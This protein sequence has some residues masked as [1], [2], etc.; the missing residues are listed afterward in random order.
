L[1][2]SSS[3]AGGTVLPDGDAGRLSSGTSVAAAAT[4]V[5]SPEPEPAAL[6]ESSLAVESG[7]LGVQRGM[8]GRD[9]ESTLEAGTGGGAAPE[10][11]DETE[12]S[13]SL[14][15][16]RFGI[17]LATVTGSTESP[18]GRRVLAS[19]A[20]SFTSFPLSDLSSESGLTAGVFRTT[21]SG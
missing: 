14:A 4:S 1:A 8:V 7:S 6:D 17:D 20:P 5:T 12:E 3:T 10:A 15:D 16:E 2:S 11:E 18:K 13:E 19:P 21:V 9:A